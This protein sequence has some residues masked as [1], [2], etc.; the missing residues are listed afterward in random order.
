M[1]P[2]NYGEVKKIAIP[3]PRCQISNLSCLNAIRRGYFAM[4]ATPKKLGMRLFAT[5]S[6]ELYVHCVPNIVCL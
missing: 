2:I 5:N 1:K 6:T 3:S 4:L